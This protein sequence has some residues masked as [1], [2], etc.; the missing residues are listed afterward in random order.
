MEQWRAML[1]RGPAALSELADAALLRDLWKLPPFTSQGRIPKAP[2]AKEV[3]LGQ[4]PY[5]G[6]AAECCQPAPGWVRAACWA[7]RLMMRDFLSTACSCWLS[8]CSYC[9]LW[10]NQAFLGSGYSLS[11]LYRQCIVIV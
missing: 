4:A 2:F 8:G 1:L 9:W 5:G 7:C 3:P 11:S 6:S 10:G